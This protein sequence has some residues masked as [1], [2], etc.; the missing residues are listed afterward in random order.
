MSKLIINNHSTG[1]SRELH[2][3]KPQHHE[4]LKHTLTPWESVE[5]GILAKNITSYGNYYVCGII[6]AD[7]KEHQE[8]MKHIVKCVNS[9]EAL[10]ESVKLAIKTF[11]KTGEEPGFIIDTL[12]TAL[13]L[14][15]E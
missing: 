13:K 8:N 3:S 10:V 1:T 14:A 7:N 4:K 9:H 6:D 5:H 2:Y 11:S 15:G 12:Q